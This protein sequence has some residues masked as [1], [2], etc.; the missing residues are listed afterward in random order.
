MSNLVAA[1]DIGTNT[2]RLLIGNR[3]TDGTITHRHI[4][5][6]ITRLGGGFSKENGIPFE[7][8]QRTV[9]AIAE[10]VSDMNQFGVGKVRAVA[11]SAVRDAVNGNVFCS[12]V[13]KRTGIVPE[14]IDG[15]TEAALTL[16]GVLASTAHGTPGILVFDVGGGST[17][18]IF[19]V[20]GRLICSESL[21]LG[22]VRLTEGKVTLDAMKDKISREMTQLR[23]LFVNKEIVSHFPS[24]S[25]I[26]TAGTATTLAAISLGMIDYDYRRINAHSLSLR[27]IKN[28]YGKLLPL[29]PAERLLVPGLEKG[30]EDL[31]I[32][33]LLITI[34]TMEVFGF[35]RLYVSDFGLLEGIFQELLES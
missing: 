26:G 17:E 23:E 4:R 28:I 8:R 16:K 20:H 15:A 27:E 7:A 35:K 32:A 29:S 3:E 34:Q 19:S 24:A 13:A 18:Y 25:L 11:T 30:R 9:N 22:V 12:E 31:I 1:I 10:F 33:G 21:P 6:I 2:S 5:R 14:I